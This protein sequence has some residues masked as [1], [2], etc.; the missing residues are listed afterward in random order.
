MFSDIEIRGRWGSA[1]DMVSAE[2]PSPDGLLRWVVIL[3]T[4]GLKIS[5][6]G[7]ALWLLFPPPLV[8]IEM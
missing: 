5:L 7:K 2:R 1:V 3:S 8:A 6:E 4:I